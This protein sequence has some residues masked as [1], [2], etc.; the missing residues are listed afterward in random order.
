MTA[1]NVYRRGSNDTN[2]PVVIATGLTNMSYSDNDVVRGGGYLY[3]V[4]AVKNGVEKISTEIKRYALGDSAFIFRTPFLENIIDEKGKTWTSQGSSTISDGAL[5]LL[6]NGTNPSYLRTPISNFSRVFTTS[7]FTIR[8]KAKFRQVARDHIFVSCRDYNQGAGFWF[9][10]VGGLLTLVTYNNS[11]TPAVNLT[12]AITVNTSDFFN[13]SMERKSQKYYLYCNEVLVASYEIA[14]A[15]KTPTNSII[16]GAGLGVL[17]DDIRYLFN[18]W[19]KDFQM[20]DE[21]LGDGGL[22][23]PNF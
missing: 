15:I 8:F 4:G 6:N 14:T 22:T 1:F 12:V 2:P 10:Y 3:S 21:P 11:T 23:T 17:S 5:S 16:G 9:G 20:I 18:G 19:I 13:F 7:D